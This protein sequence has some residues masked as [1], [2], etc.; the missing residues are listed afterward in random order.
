MNM[1]A[2]PMQMQPGAQAMPAMGQGSQ[3]DP[4]LVQ[5]ILAMQQQGAQQGAID[6]QRKMAE[7]LRADAGQ[8]MQG[9]MAGATYAPPTALNAAAK[10]F[11]DYKA[12]GMQDD[13]SV[14]E[15]NMGVQNTDAMRRY[16]EA[17]TRSKGA[18]VPYM[19]AEG[20]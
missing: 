14:R 17:L 9:R 15:Q 7:M 4:Q 10:L 6:R 8:Q 18:P 20:E 19:G 1:Q 11:S 13:A 5:A 3:L 16:F 12:K 2:A